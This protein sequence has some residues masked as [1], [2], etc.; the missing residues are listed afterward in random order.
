M[1]YSTEEA[2]KEIMR[3][4]RLI[5]LQREKQ[6]VG[7]Y[8]LASLFVLGVL[9]VLISGMAE[10]TVPADGQEVMGSF[11]LPA[12]AGAYVLTAVLAFT[13]GVVLT[14]ITQKC[15]GKRK[16]KV[17]SWALSLMLVFTMM[18]PL[19]AAVYADD[20]DGSPAISIGAGN[21][22][23]GNKVYMGIRFVSE[24]PA[25]ISWLVLGDANSTN[26][27]DDEQSVDAKNARLLITEKTQGN[28]MFDPEAASNVWQGS[29]IQSWCTGTFL[30]DY[31]FNGE[32]YQEHFNELEKE[33]ML[34][35]SKE[36]GEYY[37]E[38]DN[39]YGTS[40][41]NN[42][43]VFLLS[44]EEV[45][46][47]SGYF[48]GDESR[49]AYQHDEDKAMDWWL[50][51]PYIY[52]SAYA[53][54]VT[55]NGDVG[56]NL[57]DWEFGA[58]PAFN[59]DLNSVLF[60]SAAAGSKSSGAAGSSALTAVSTNPTNEWKMTLHVSSRDG[61]TAN[62][63]TGATLSADEGYTSWS[64]PIVFSGASDANDNDYVSLILADSNDK[65]L[66][67]GNIA[68]KTAASAD[69]GQ[70][71]TI[72]AGLAA[73]DYKLYVFSEQVNGDKRSD[74]ASAF[75]TIKLKVNEYPPSDPPTESFTVTFKALGGIWAD[76][77]TA[78]KQVT[79][80]KGQ[81][82]NAPADP[83]KEG[84]AFDGWDTDFSNV[85]TDL[86]VTAKWEENTT[87]P[88]PE[89]TKIAVPTGKTLTYN[90]KTQ[91]G[92]AA[93]ANYVLSGTT[94][95]TNAGSYTAKAALKTNANYTYKW[96]DG[97]TATKTIKWKINKAANTLT[98]KPK[99]AT[100]KYSKL[101]KK[102]QT[103]SVTKVI[104]FTKD[105]KDKKTYTLSSVKKGKKSFKSKFKINKTTGK[106]T[107]K[108]G[109]KKGT[110][111][112][113]AKVKA[114]GNANYKASTW[115]TVAFKVRVR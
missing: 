110:Y 22:E 33:T 3:R 115:K 109:L 62:A 21:I 36:D 16:K 97:T 53:A 68:N 78:D 24:N 49:I 95:A 47:D 90:A 30:N 86:T 88:E 85:T 2:S 87:P 54:C 113:K 19:S 43:Q 82:A 61:F 70:Q 73:G 66:Y 39:Y 100:V 6:S 20:G 65:A 114:A 32:R 8:S 48:S 46:D 12:K 72:P 37:G 112:V 74:Y 59:I 50:R 28:N 52:H 40:S 63:A 10:G 79:V 60:T 14:M 80:E 105:A 56:Y 91:T 27:K 11:L 71:V 67:Y 1:K 17:I 25:P 93:G 81:A 92:V 13:L 104:R 51:S 89:P 26:L 98:I 4:S 102:T 44:V 77:T 103:L 69:T 35:T 84:F 5:E 76:G 15:R 7:L 55:P 64:V 34:Y 108:K 31:D 38:G 99:T 41:L 57:V 9:G 23:K 107:V 29:N 45:S 18:P 42:E 94:K 58:R 83:T 111:K 75:K 96:S 106:V 101:K